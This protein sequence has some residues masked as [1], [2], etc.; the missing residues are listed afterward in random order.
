MSLISQ[1]DALPDDMK[2]LCGS[3]AYG[4]IGE[5]WIHSVFR[6]GADVYRIVLIGWEICPVDDGGFVPVDDDGFPL[7][8]IAHGWGKEDFLRELNIKHL[9]DMEEAGVYDI[10]GEVDDGVWRGGV[11]F[12]CQR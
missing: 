11:F 3:F 9:G 4:F 10:L 6:V 8:E 1:I 2:V 12:Q 5:K 7:D